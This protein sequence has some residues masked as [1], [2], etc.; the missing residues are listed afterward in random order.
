MNPETNRIEEVPRTVQGAEYM[1]IFVLPAVGKRVASF[2]GYHWK[3]K[4]VNIETQ[5]VILEQDG[6][7]AMGQKVKGG[8]R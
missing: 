2:A 8:S 1:D 7:T 4:T 5:E 6:L 3:V